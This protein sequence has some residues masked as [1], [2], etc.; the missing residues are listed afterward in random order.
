MIRPLRNEL[1]SVCDRNVIQKLGHIGWVAD[2]KHG[3]KQTCRQGPHLDASPGGWWMG[4]NI[5][6]AR[7]DHACGPSHPASRL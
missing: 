1:V 5:G 4:R 3:P 6:I 7:M 2:Y